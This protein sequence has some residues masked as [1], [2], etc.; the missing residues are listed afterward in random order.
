MLVKSSEEWPEG[1]QYSTKEQ[2]DEELRSFA[3]TLHGYSPE[4]YKYIRKCFKE[5]L[6]HPKTISEWYRNADEKPDLC[7]ETCALLGRKCR[8]AVKIYPLLCVS[9]QRHVPVFR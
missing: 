6:P 5:C 9:I 8:N 1:E 2:Y 4:A 7:E 3:V